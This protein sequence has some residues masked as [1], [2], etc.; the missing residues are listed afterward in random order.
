MNFIFFA[1]NA[2]E[3]IVAAQHPVHRTDYAAKHRQQQRDDH[4]TRHRKQKFDML[5]RS[6]K[7][8]EKYRRRTDDADQRQQQ[9][10]DPGK[11]SAEVK[12]MPAAPP[13]APGKFHHRRPVVMQSFDKIPDRI[14]G[15]GG[16]PGTGMVMA[17]GTPAAFTGN[18][19]VIIIV[20]DDHFPTPVYI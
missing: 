3:I 10:A 12:I 7:E 14:C 6:V 19:T 17:A 20:V 9:M 2:L 1:V 16:S 18:R 8:N 5:F 11:N 4:Q 13:H 15:I